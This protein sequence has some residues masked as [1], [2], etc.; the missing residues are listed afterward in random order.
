[1]DLGPL[2][3]RWLCTLVVALTLFPFVLYLNV[4]EVSD[5]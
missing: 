5:E 4:K 2:E 3:F 1:M